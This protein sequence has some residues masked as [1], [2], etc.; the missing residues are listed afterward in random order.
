MKIA[1]IT[2]T[3]FGAL[4]LTVTGVTAAH[5]DGKFTESGSLSCKSGQVVELDVSYSGYGKA[6]YNISRT[7]VDVAG[8]PL[9]RPNGDEQPG[10]NARSTLRFK[11][12]RQSSQW[13]IWM[14]TG[15]SHTT[16][17]CVSR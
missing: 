10:H 12:Q 8:L 7:N 1:R 3:F 16:A 9:A 4:A 14:E 17:N 2:A 15:N 5:A 13:N 11:T 6:R